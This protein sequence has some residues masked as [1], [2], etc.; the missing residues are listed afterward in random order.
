MDTSRQHPTDHHKNF[1]F[2]NFIICQL[3][4][5]NYLA[6]LHGVVADSVAV[7]SFAGFV[8]DSVDSDAVVEG[9]GGVVETKFS[10]LIPV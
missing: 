2:R 10:H 5:I 6:A 4:I 8:V 7:V 3:H 1:V 9:G